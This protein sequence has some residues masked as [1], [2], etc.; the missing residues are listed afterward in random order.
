MRS[1]AALGL[2]SPKAPASPAPAIARQPSFYR[3]TWDD[4]GMSVPAAEL[5]GSILERAGKLAELHKTHRPTFE[6]TEATHLMTEMLHIAVHGNTWARSESPEQVWLDLLA[7]VW[8]AH[9]R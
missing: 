1:V 2:S 8:R 9:L 3:L 4:A 5:P 6:L 7:E